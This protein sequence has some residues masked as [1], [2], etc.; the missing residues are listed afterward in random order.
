MRALPKFVVKTVGTESWWDH[1]FSM[2]G[3]LAREV[4]VYRLRL[5]KSGEVKSVIQELVESP[6]S[7][8]AGVAKE[9]V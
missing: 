1:V 8:V 4:P 5:D 9:R 3:Q 7:I 2:I 6:A